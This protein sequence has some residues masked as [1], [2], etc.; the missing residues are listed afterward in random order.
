MEW[1]IGCDGH[2]RQSRNGSS[3]CES[4]SQFATQRLSLL[5]LHIGLGEHVVVDEALTCEC[6]VQ[7]QEWLSYRAICGSPRGL[8]ED[9]PKPGRK[10][11]QRDLADRHGL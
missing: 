1:E 8:K 7:A 6:A 9:E 5:D 3:G 10:A 2:E 11:L 4:R